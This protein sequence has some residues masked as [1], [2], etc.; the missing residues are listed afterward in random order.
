M[1][2]RRSGE[3]SGGDRFLLVGDSARRPLFPYSG[4][5]SGAAAGAA[6]GTAAAIDRWQRNGPPCERFFIGL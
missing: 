1:L 6:A 2:R 4:A 5:V 3:D